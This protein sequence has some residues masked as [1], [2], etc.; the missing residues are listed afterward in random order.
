MRF[1]VVVGLAAFS[2]CSGALSAYAQTATG[3]DAEEIVVTATKTGE[4]RIQDT[5]IAISAFG[6]D[7][8]SRLGV[9][10]IRG[11][12]EMTPNLAIS[13]NTGFSQVFIRGIGS[14]N[15]FAGSDPSSTL[16]MDGVYLARPVTYFSGL[17]DVE[18]V[19]VLR[20]P[21]GT[22]YGRNSVGGTI[23][24]VSRKPHDELSGKVELGYG[25]YDA[26]HAGV[27][28]NVPLGP[29][30][31]ASIAGLYSK[32]DGYVKNINPSGND[33]DDDDTKGVRT[34]LRWNPGRVDAVLRA[35]YSR[36]EGA[37]MGFSKL[38]EPRGNA[39][40]DNLLG[41][42]HRIA[43]N[44]PHEYYVKNYGVAADITVELADTVDLRSLTSYRKS[45]YH[46]SFDTDAS[47]L[48]LQRSLL[49]E[50]Q[51][52]FSQEFNLTGKFGPLSIIAGAF[53]FKE[54]MDY[55]I[56]IEVRTAG[57]AVTA[58]P[59]VV[60][61]S[62]AFFQQSDL[63]L[64]DS[65]KVTFGLRYTEEEKKF[66]QN[67]AIKSLVT[68]LPVSA[69]TVYD[70][71]GNYKAWTPKF[72]LEWQPADDIMLYASASRGFKSGGFVNGSTNPN[73]GF[74]PE[75]LWAY[76][77]GVKSEWLERRLTLNLSTFY[78]EYSDLQVNFF[79]APGVVDIRNA[80]DATVKGLEFEFG[81]RP[82]PTTRLQGSVSLLDA[83]YD[84]FP[85]APR[86]GNQAVFDASGAYLNN[87]P[88]HL[89]ALSLEQ[90]FPD[91]AGAQPSLQIDGSWN[92]RR[93]F[94]PENNLLE[95]QGNYFLLNASFQ[96]QFEN[97]VA[98][99]LWGRNLTNKEYVTGTASFASALV[100]GRVGS[101]RTFGA[102]VGYNF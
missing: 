95:S 62:F 60:T 43:N 12:A 68:G 51:D 48:D 19:E 20:G 84:S 63:S 89:V 5:P 73:Q 23:N 49:D 82:F 16:H 44:V 1:G 99:T 88:K 35:D 24:V 77:V 46:A 56:A 14:N 8:L 33:I 74:G 97:G 72:G 7:Q 54:S 4:T 93:Y 45:R 98:V 3:F 94:T 92:G 58:A 10:N 85:N 55:P 100:A 36:S 61:E 86:R 52:Q 13:E 25:N 96:M 71:E 34:Q 31:F 29:D 47:A 69:V 78:Y 9:S 50:F 67:H 30:L 27:Y 17:F 42:Y 102:K 91:I 11:I 79:L 38:L 64:S 22:I 40:T 26:L 21:Q 57:T 83:K 90:K 15:V 70:T 81:I 41:D 101:P 18:R 6:G 39:M 66:S 80:A 59:H 32:H 76:E 65:F 28:V 53:Y 75:K 37:I 87:A 2:A